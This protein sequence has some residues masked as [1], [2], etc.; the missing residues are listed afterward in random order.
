MHIYID[1]DYVRYIYAYVKFSLVY[2]KIG[3]SLPFHLYKDHMI[4][5]EMLFI[6]NHN[7]EVT[8]Y[9]MREKMH[10]ILGLSI[11]NYLTTES[12]YWSP[13]NIFSVMQRVTCQV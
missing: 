1:S 5:G 10:H 9:N 13:R 2:R 7:D 12:A 3:V 8:N 4:S 11:I 6:M